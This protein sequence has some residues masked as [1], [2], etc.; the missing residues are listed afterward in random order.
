M[1]FVGDPKKFNFLVLRLFRWDLDY[2]KYSYSYVQYMYNHFKQL[3]NSNWLN[4]QINL[5]LQTNKQT[6]IFNLCKIKK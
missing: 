4:K 3:N 6:N 1:S 5:C 2:T